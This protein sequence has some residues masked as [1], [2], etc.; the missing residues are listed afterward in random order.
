MRSGG[1]P[2]EYDLCN[3]RAAEQ[4]RLVDAA[5]PHSAEIAR[6]HHSRVR[7]A[8]GVP[9]QKGA[10]PRGSVL[11]HPKGLLCEIAPA[12]GPERPRHL[13]ATAGREEIERQ[14]G[15]VF[16]SNPLYWGLGVSPEEYMHVPRGAK[17]N[18]A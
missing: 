6:P 17:S 7:L 18:E 5:A 12:D 1:Q 16:P 13:A 3:F 10:I 14:F 4:A 2:T 8:V 11:P 9:A 15:Y